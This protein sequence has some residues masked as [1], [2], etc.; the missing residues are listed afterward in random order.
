MAEQLP[1]GLLKGMLF[2]CQRT[3]EVTLGSNRG[4]SLYF[5]S[6]F[7]ERALD[8]GCLTGNEI[9]LRAAILLQ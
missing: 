3:Q 9:S 5:T 6:H 8:K 7:S 4:A 1:R 2:Y